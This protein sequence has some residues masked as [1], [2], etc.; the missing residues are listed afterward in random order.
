MWLLNI[1]IAEILDGNEN[2]NNLRRL[3]CRALQTS[4]IGLNEQIVNLILVF[5]YQRRLIL[6]IYE[7]IVQHLV[8]HTAYELM[9]QLIKSTVH[10]RIPLK[11]K[12]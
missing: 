4:V 12:Q 1:D 11:Q 5:S 7:E 10:I 8:E 2:Y 9:I 3:T 6:H